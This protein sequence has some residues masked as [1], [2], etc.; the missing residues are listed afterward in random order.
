MR[1][2]D[3][4]FLQ[5]V[6]DE[7]IPMQGRMVHD[8]T[9]P[10]SVVEEARDRGEKHWLEGETQQYDIHGQF[11]RSADRHRLNE[12]LLDRIAVEEDV[13]LFFNHGLK[14]VDLDKKVATFEKRCVRFVR[15]R[16]IC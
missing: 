13:K 15:K 10:A 11:I 1:A 5:S 14:H 3:P 6:L 9:R 7:T 8:C 16:D 2:I 4:K 12:Q